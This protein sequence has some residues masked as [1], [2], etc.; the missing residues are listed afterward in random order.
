MTI[1]PIKTKADHKAALAEIE[2]L[3]DAAPNTPEGDMLDELVTLVEAYEE[4]HEPIAP[5]DPV[6]SNS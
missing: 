5:P 3:F 1:R 6:A 2:R 4:L